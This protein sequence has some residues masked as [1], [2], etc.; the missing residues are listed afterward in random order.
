MRGSGLTYLNYNSISFQ[1]CRAKSNEMLCGDAGRKLTTVWDVSGR[2]DQA[3]KKAEQTIGRTMR[4]GKVLTRFCNTFK[5]AGS[6]EIIL[7]V[8]DI[9]F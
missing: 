4:C 9:Q 7:I 8:C 1:N 5:H 2:T 3:M 6:C